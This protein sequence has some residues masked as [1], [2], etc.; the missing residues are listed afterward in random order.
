M[1]NSRKMPR[2]AHNGGDRRHGR[3]LKETLERGRQSYPG[4]EELDD[5][6]PEDVEESL[7][8]RREKMNE[9]LGYTPDYE[10]GY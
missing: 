5:W 10:G 3:S 7:R 9:N 8:L 1:P 6:A 4:S 2:T